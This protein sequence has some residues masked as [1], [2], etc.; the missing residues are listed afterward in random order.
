MIFLEWLKL[1]SP[2]IVFWLLYMS[3]SKVGEVRR[4]T[5]NYCSPLC[6]YSVTNPNQ[7]ISKTKLHLSAMTKRFSCHRDPSPWPRFRNCCEESSKE[8]GDYVGVADSLI[9]R[10]IKMNKQMSGDKWH[11]YNTRHWK[12]KFGQFG[13][14]IRTSWKSQNRTL[15]LRLREVASW[16]W[17]EHLKVL[18]RVAYVC[19]I[20]LGLTSRYH[21]QW[22]LLHIHISFF[23]SFFLLKCVTIYWNVPNFKLIV[24]LYI[25]TRTIIDLNNL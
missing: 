4:C 18:F 24:S 13:I 20:K 12:H 9:C 1:V 3:F 23:L 14:L 2:K 8:T 17:S 6:F 25:L 5:R 16:D 22:D 11:R 19:S 7:V 15:H 21:T 10:L